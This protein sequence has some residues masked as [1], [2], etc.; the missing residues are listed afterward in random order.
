MK[1]NT[2][3]IDLKL[4]FTSFAVVLLLGILAVL[5]P[6]AVKGT[7]GSMLDFT[8]INFG[9][10]FL[11]YTLF[12]TFALLY[13]AFSKFGNIRMGDSKP[14]FS[15]FQ[16]F[17]MALSAG[18]GA[19][20]MYWGFIESVY[21]FMDPQFGI[22]DKHMAMEYAT[23]YNMFH[24][25][26]AGWFIYLIVAIPFAVVFY[27]K[28]SQRMSLSGV[29]NSLFNDSLPVWAQKLIDL[30]F[31]ITTL[32]ATALTLGLGIPMISSNLASLTGIP[33]NLML[34][35]GVILGLSVIFSLSSYIGIEKGMARLSSA[36]IYICAAFV[37]I[38]FIIGPSALIMNNLTNGIGVMLTEYLRMSTNTDPYGT[39]L[40]PQYWTV[41]FL[42]NW[43]SYSPG[44]GVFITKII[45]GQKLR[46]V[47]LILVI[48]GTLGSA[49]IFGVCGTYSMNLI[50]TG[51]V[52]GVA[53]IQAGQ[54]T[55][56]VKDIFGQSPV[57]M[58]LTAI[59]LI[60]MILFTVT[61]LDGTSYSLAGIAT[62]ELDAEANVSPMFRLFWCLLLTALPIVF[63]LINADLNILKSFPVL[64]IVLIMPVFFVAAV[65]T[66]QYLNQ[67]YG[68]IMA[69]QREQDKLLGLEEEETIVAAP[70][71]A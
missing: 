66:L 4:T 68:R 62:K 51:V 24:W 58:L 36:T 63:L 60:T 10:G 1:L 50:N 54:P 30:L 7:M 43:I 34:G 16:L 19:S 6:E 67:N 71:T 69:H 42:A 41:F 11:W 37:G 47:V 56:L 12:A 39:T 59:Y 17:A 65:K 35:I 2:S 13:L 9:S 70:Q 8:V 27:L 32:A 20:T 18:M 29:I 22:A 49:V 40:F 14:K 46:D 25:G 31:I 53:L 15:K 3:G 44:V 55:T 5:Y 33:D 48:G 23:A 38:I 61:T 28:K 26:A 57:P 21:Y 45:Q 52:D 64:I